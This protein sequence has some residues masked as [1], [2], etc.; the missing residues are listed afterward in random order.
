MSPK[1][2]YIESLPQMWWHW[3]IGP[4]EIIVLDKSRRRGPHDAIT[5]LI[6]RERDSRALSLSVSLSVV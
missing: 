2:A 1:N 6:R 5:T 3:D 4:L